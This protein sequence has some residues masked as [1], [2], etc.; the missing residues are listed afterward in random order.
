MIWTYDCALPPRDQLKRTYGLSDYS[1]NKILIN[2]KEDGLIIRG[3]GHGEATH[4]IG[5]YGKERYFSMLFT[6][7]YPNGIAK[8]Q[9]FYEDEAF[10]RRLLRNGM[11]Q[12][13]V[14]GD[15]RKRI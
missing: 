10:Y 2:L 1:L 6:Q 9:L 12:R 7:R 8:G 14:P 3:Y 5:S 11:L 4:Y 15:N 13:L